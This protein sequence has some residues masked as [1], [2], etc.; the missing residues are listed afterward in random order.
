MEPMRIVKATV[1][2]SGMLIGDRI[3][4]A[5]NS[6]T[7]FVGL[8]GRRTLDA[9]TGLWIRPCSGVHTIGMSI[10]IDVIGL[11]KKLQVIALWPNLLPWR[12]TRVSWRMSSVVELPVGSIGQYG[13]KIGDTLNIVPAD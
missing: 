10:A 1:E 4:L 3:E 6:W 7:R 12:L 5:N 13:V 8:L 11:D 9:G 2:R